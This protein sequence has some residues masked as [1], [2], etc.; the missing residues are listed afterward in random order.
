MRQIGAIRYFVLM[1]ALVM[2]YSLSALERVVHYPSVDQYGD[3]LL[4]SGKVTIP[5]TDSIKGIILLLHYTISSDAE[6]PSNTTISE[7]KVFQDDYVLIMPDY[8][9]YGLT[10]DRIHPYLHGSLTAHNAVDMLLYTRALL[11]S[12]QVAPYSDGI[13]IVGY[14]QGG[15][16]ALWTQRLLEEQYAEQIPIRACFAGSGPYDV[17][18]TF[19]DAVMRNRVGLPLVVPYLVIGTKVAYGLEVDCEA[20]F[21][22]AMQ[23]KYTR[24]II[25]KEYGIGS[26]Y[27][28]MPQHRLCHWMTKEGMDKASPATKKIYEGLLQSSLVHYAIDDSEVGSDSIV[29]AWRPH[30]PTYIFHSKKD[31]VV[32]FYNALHLQRAMGALPNVTYDFGHYGGHLRSAMTFFPRVRERMK[33]LTN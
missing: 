16:V 24:Y 18:T 3:S 21:T 20:F 5:E 11:D 1:S 31:E 26:L 4:L 28:R 32:T 17:A 22:A 14:S 23:K 19:D 8:I 33:E 9:G 6:A 2:C 25:N 30:S 10:R 7:A 29:P 15:A 27:F 12:M 13:Y